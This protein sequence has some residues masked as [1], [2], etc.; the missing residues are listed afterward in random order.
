[1]NDWQPRKCPSSKVW[2]WGGY[3]VPTQALP[4]WED[5]VLQKFGAGVPWH[6]RGVTASQ[7]TSLGPC[8][9]VAEAPG[10]QGWAHPTWGPVLARGCGW[11]ESPYQAPLTQEGPPSCGVA[12]TVPVSQGRKLRFWEVQR[13]SPMS[14]HLVR[15]NA[16]SRELLTQGSYSWLPLETWGSARHP[17]HSWG[18]KVDVSLLLGTQLS[19]WAT[20]HRRKKGCGF[21]SQGSP[22]RPPNEEKGFAGEACLPTPDCKLGNGL[23]LQTWSARW[24]AI[25]NPPGTAWPGP[26]RG[27]SFIH[28]PWHS[29]FCTMASGMGWVDSNSLR[30]RLW[31]GLGDFE[32][33]VPSAPLPRLGRIENHKGL[34]VP[35]KLGLFPSWLRTLPGLELWD[36]QQVSSSRKWTWG[37]QGPASSPTLGRLCK[38]DLETQFPSWEGKDLTFLE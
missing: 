20:G 32:P 26:R 19:G 2:G 4:G 12:I 30:K 28:L 36:L 34:V 7:L 21:W 37:I 18:Y 3:G 14:I 38:P 35:Q 23:S 8:P 25:N 15:S 33:R 27:A 31:E 5:D 22:R 10:Q 6:C 9:A 13:L 17:D 16:Q 11:G 1:M 24:R 29:S